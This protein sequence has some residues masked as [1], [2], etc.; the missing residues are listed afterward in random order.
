[1][2]SSL[3]FQASIITVT[4]SIVTLKE[5]QNTN[6]FVAS[7]ICDS[8]ISSTNTITSDTGGPGDINFNQS[9]S[10]LITLPTDDEGRKKAALVLVGEFFDPDNSSSSNNNYQSCLGFNE[11]E[12]IIDDDDN[13]GTEHSRRVVLYDKNGRSVGNVQYSVSIEESSIEVDEMMSSNEWNLTEQ[14]SLFYDLDMMTS[15]PSQG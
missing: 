14:I 4:V 11:I 3:R 9:L 2:T 10:L 8:K 15:S 13:D 1:M 5:N 6:S 7:L 12:I